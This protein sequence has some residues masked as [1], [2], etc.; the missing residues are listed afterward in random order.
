MARVEIPAPGDLIMDSAGNVR[1]GVTVTLTLA[2]TGTAATHYSALTGGT[3]TTGG[4]VSGAVGDVVDG[5]GNRRY[6]DS[7]IPMDMTISGRLKRLEPMSALVARTVATGGS[8]GS[9]YTPDIAGRQD[10]LIQGT[11]S[12]DLTV[13]TPTNAPAGATVTFDLTQDA[14]TARSVTWFSASQ[15]AGSIGAVDPTLGS[16]TVV[17]FYTPDGST[18]VGWSTRLGTLDLLRSK[19]YYAE[20]AGTVTPSLQSAVSGT[21]AT[22]VANS[23]HDAPND[24][25]G[26]YDVTCRSSPAPVA[27]DVLNLAFTAGYVNSAGT[28]KRPRIFIEAHT[29]AAAD[30]RLYVAPFTTLFTLKCRVAPAASDVLTFSYWVIG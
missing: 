30:A 21:G 22:V 20:S 18:W 10:T 27:G 15:P 5:S 6:V 1:V 29:A 13:G 8:L 2:G 7:G 24:A 11:L 3:S 4:L 25:C 12:A 14:V 19:R 26:T 17:S 16:R 28:A 23:S 9:S